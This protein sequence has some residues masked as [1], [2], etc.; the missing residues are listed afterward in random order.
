[1]DIKRS[2]RSGSQAPITQSNTEVFKSLFPTTHFNIRDIYYGT[3]ITGTAVRNIQR[4]NSTFS[5]NDEFGIIVHHLMTSERSF[6]FNLTI[7]IENKKLAITG[8]LEM[9]DAFESEWPDS[10][11]SDSTNALKFEWD[12]RE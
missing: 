3:L 8:T 1:M 9:H 4:G 10:F 5:N 2:N 12:F 6:S 11:M 7:D